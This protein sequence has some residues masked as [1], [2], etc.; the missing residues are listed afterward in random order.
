MKR[1]SIEQTKEIPQHMQG[2]PDLPVNLRINCKS[3]RVLILPCEAETITKGGII[4][5]DT[6][7]EKPQ[8]GVVVK[9][10][11]GKWEEPMEVKVGEVV[12][13]GKY[14]GSEVDFD[15]KT[16]LLMRLSDISAEVY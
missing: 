14:A 5:P 6:A 11:P 9:V 16:Y 13:Y 12:L 3:D 1:E 15:G 8:R 4:V 10:G 7:K 2:V